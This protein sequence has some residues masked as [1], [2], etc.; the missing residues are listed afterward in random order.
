MHLLL[1]NA[2]T[3]AAMTGVLVGAAR[4]IVGNGITVTGATGRF[5][6][7][8][9]ATRPAYAIAAHATLDAYA[10]NGGDADAVIIACFGDPGLLALRELASVP[11][12]GMAE[13]SCQQAASVGRFSIV[14]GGIGW[15]AMLEEFVTMIGVG[16]RLAAVRAVTASG[17]EIAADPK[18]YE[19][20]LAQ[21]CRAA[22]AENGAEVVVL[23]GA[24]LV[25]IA[26]RIASEVPVPLIDCLAAAV[27]RAEQIMTA[28]QS[29]S[30]PVP[31]ARP[32]ETIG[33][34]DRLAHLLSSERDKGKRV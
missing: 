1:I 25:G 14:T 4:S 13:A 18:G 17:G 12:V 15:I 22:V 2:N 8:Y 7:R 3:T 31:D 10:E 19:R 9:I 32:V 20:I 21:E 24:G 16:E 11:V 26:E 29:A 28:P 6:A 30:M 5:G 27:K 23:G 33:L 34:P